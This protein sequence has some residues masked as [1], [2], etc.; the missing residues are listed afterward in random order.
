MV[1]GGKKQLALKMFVLFLVMTPYFSLFYQFDTIGSLGPELEQEAGISISQIG[2]LY[3]AYGLVTVPVALTSG[4]LID[5][6]GLNSMIIISSTPICIGALLISIAGAQKP[7]LFWLMFVGRIF[8]G[9]CEALLV[10]QN[11][12]C[13]IWFQ[14]YWRN[15]SFSLSF[16]WAQVGTALVFAL[17]PAVAHLG[18]GWALSAGFIISVFSIFSSVVYIIMDKRGFLTRLFEVN[19]LTSYRPK[20]KLRDVTKLPLTYWCLVIIRGSNAGAAFTFIM[21]GPSFLVATTN[22]DP[23]VS[24]FIISAMNLEALFGPIIGLFLDRYGR[25]PIIWCISC[26]TISISYLVLALEVLDPI[27]WI[28]LVGFTYT[29]VNSSVTSCISL[30]GQVSFS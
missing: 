2:Q 21:Y 23:Q 25:R 3:L 22:Y 30:V 20:M 15:I 26:L 7:A 17:S 1:P 24:G 8:V 4:V 6:L 12:I 13:G 14:G 29:V 19:P 5:K 10:C 9:L 16:L 18:I 27:F 11:T 28:L